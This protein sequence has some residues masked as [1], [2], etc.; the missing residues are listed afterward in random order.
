MAQF[1]MGELEIMKILWEHGALKPSD[2]QRLYPRPIKNAAMRAALRVLV[3]KGHVGRS[4]NGKAFFYEA[5]TPQQNAMR[6]MVQKMKDVFYGGSSAAL[7]AHL[8]ETEDLSKDD[9]E[10]LQRIADQKL[11]RESN[12]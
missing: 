12:K 10:E 2:L 5:I 6:K 8:M 7:I 9:I 3:E 1:T 4:K 11:D